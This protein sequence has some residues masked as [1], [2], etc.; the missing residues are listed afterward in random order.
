MKTA[1]SSCTGAY[2]SAFSAQYNG[3]CVR[4]AANTP[5][6]IS[7]FTAH[8]SSHITTKR[9]VTLNLTTS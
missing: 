2:H 6:A 4:T 9:T 8:Q 5:S 7:Q 1:A 3:F